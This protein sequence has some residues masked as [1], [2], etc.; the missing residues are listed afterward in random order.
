VAQA[1]EEG[2]AQRLGAQVQPAR[3]VVAH[4]GGRELGEDVQHLDRGGTTGGPRRED[5]LEPAVLHVERLDHARLVAL[6]V[7]RA[8]EAA[9]PPHLLVDGLRDGAPVECGRPVLGDEAEA[10]AEIGLAQ[11]VGGGE[12][13][14][15]VDVVAA[16]QVG[17]GG[18]RERG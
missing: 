13:G 12:R 11:H 1:V 8:Q 3:R 16:A 4:L 18:L 2:V 9:G 7:A 10:P 15:P 6:E 17:A 5:Q 14:G